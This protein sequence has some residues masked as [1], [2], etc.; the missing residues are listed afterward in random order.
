MDTMSL[1]EKILLDVYPGG[2]ANGWLCSLI[3]PLIQLV[4]L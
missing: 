2:C 1:E 4:S 3:K